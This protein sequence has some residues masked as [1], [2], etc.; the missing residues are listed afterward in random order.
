MAIL[1]DYGFPEGFSIAADHLPDHAL[2]ALLAHGPW[3]GGP[4]PGTAPDTGAPD[5]GGAGTGPELIIVGTD[6][7]GL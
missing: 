6:S 7:A 3:F 5:P 1:I 2:D 4:G